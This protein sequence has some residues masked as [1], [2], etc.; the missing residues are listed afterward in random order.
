MKIMSKKVKFFG[1][2]IPAVAIALI[3]IAALASAGLLTMYGKLVGTAEVHQSVKLYDGTKWLEC[4]GGNYSQC[5]IEYTVGESP[6]VAGSTY[7]NGPFNLKNDAQVPATVKLVTT[8]CIKDSVDCATEGHKEAGITTTYSTE[9]TDDN[10][11]FGSKSNEVVAIVPEGTLTLDDLFA[12]NGLKYE[13]TVVEGG[14]Y[15][16]ASPII[17]VLDLSDGR[18]IVLFPGWDTRNINNPFYLQFSDTVAIANS[19][20]HSNEAVDFVVYDSTFHKIWSSPGNYPAWTGIKASPNVPVN[21]KEIVTRVAIQHQGAN[22]GEKDRLESLAF[23]P[24]SYKFIQVTEGTSFPLQP[25]QEASFVIKNSFALAL[26]PDT[27]TIKTSVV[28][29]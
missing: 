12:G 19:S 15:S 1:R 3:A 2:S 18:H 29:A 27:Y 28:P 20:T 6:A 5:T 9:I 24:K 17:A 16:G 4:T 23:T 7:V 26:I 21:G 11:N 22:T 13:Y 14:T 25:G 8:Q 10:T